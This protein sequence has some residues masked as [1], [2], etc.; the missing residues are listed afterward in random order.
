MDVKNE[1]ALYKATRQGITESVKLLLA[2]GAHTDFKIEDS[3]EDKT[4]KHPIVIAAKTGA[5]D[6]VVALV[7]AR[8]NTNVSDANNTT[9]LLYALDKDDVDCVR[10]LLSL[11]KADVNVAQGKSKEKD[12]K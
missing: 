7:E 10:T 5:H 2:K 9:P 6:C 3:R 4:E 8:A 1:T 12:Y 11:G